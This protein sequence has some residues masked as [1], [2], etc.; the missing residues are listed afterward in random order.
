MTRTRQDIANDIA[1]LQEQRKA[2]QE[3]AVQLNR[4]NILLSDDEQWF[5]E[6]E[7]TWT[8]RVGRKREKYTR[9]VGR[10]NW[11]EDF[12]DEDTGEKLSINRSEVVRVDG[13]W[14]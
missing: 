6:T 13:E 1:E 11:K 9:L 8:R 14:V 10:I 2:L 5:T 12:T 4:E 7:E 3:R